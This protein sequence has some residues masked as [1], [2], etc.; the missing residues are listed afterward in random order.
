LAKENFSSALA[1]VLA[2]EGGY[3]NHPKDPGGATNMGVTQRV[4]DAYRDRRDQP[5][6]S[7]R[8]ITAA[9]VA[10]IYERQY[11][12]AIR[13]DDLPSGLDYAV[14]DYA[15]NSG[16]RRAAMDLQRELG[17][18][19]DGVIGQVTLAAVAQNDV[20]GLIEALSARRM[21]FLR[22][23]KH[24][25]T[26]GKG[27]TRRVDEMTNM[28][29]AMVANPETKRVERIVPTEIPKAVEE[30]R[31]SP[32][33]SATLQATLLDVGAKAGAGFA[34]LQTIDDRTVQLAIIGLLG[35]ALI[36]S[37]VIFR[38]RLKAW[39]EGWR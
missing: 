26:F 35:L 6:R 39:S 11:W 7:V 33:Q 13:G 23:L 2:H 9:E 36:A 25:K 24:W 34:A 18:S 15:V 21:Q 8:G 12:D 38:E 27:W 30:E 3:V 37:A 1:H 16:P 4:Y 32:V 28:A 29:M 19:V 31:T 20:Y 10:E 22:G 17:V 14:F 5:R